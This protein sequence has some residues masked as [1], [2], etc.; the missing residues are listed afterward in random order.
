[1]SQGGGRIRGREARQRSALVLV[2]E[3]ASSGHTGESRVHYPFKDLRE[4]LE[5]DYNPEGGGGVGR[6]LSRLVE[7]NAIRLLQRKGI[8]AI[9]HQWGKQV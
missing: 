5:Q 4:G 8:G 2:Q 7:D 9:G 1:V 6:R 3:A